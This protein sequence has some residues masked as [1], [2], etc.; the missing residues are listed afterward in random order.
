[1]TIHR[2]FQVTDHQHH[3]GS[4]FFFFF[5]F[6]SLESEHWIF[7]LHLIRYCVYSIYSPVS[8]V[9]LLIKVLV[10]LHFGLHSPPLPT[11]SVLHIHL[12]FSACTSLS[13]FSNFPIYVS[14]SDVTLKSIGLIF[15]IASIPIIHLNIRSTFRHI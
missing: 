9:S 1:M 7:T 3:V 15:S 10:F 5:G 14:T 13:R 12:S 11:F 4:T 6:P 8:F 2:V